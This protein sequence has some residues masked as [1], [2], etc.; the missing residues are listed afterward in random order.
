MVVAS[1]DPYQANDAYMPMQA[2]FAAADLDKDGTSLEIPIVY[3]SS[4]ALWLTMVRCSGGALKLNGESDPY[5]KIADSSNKS[6]RTTEGADITVGD[7]DGDGRSEI[8]VVRGEYNGTNKHDPDEKNRNNLSFYFYRLNGNTIEL[9][10]NFWD[11][12]SNLWRSND[13]TS[14][15]RAEAGDFDGNGRDELVYSHPG[16]SGKQGGVLY[17]SLKEWDKK[18]EGPGSKT[19]NL[20]TNSAYGWVLYENSGHHD[21]ALG[22]YKCTQNNV[23]QI[24]IAQMGGNGIDYAVMDYVN[25]A[26]STEAGFKTELGNPAVP[27]SVTA[28]DLDHETMILGEPTVVTIND[29]L[30]MLVELQAPP[31]HF[32]IIDGQTIDVLSQRAKKV[33]GNLGSVYSTAVYV[34]D[35]EGTVSSNTQAETL[36]WSVGAKIDGGGAFPTPPENGYGKVRK[37]LQSGGASANAGGSIASTEAQSNTKDIAYQTSMSMSI[38]TTDVD[39]IVYKPD[40]MTIYRYPVIY[41]VEGKGRNETR[42]VSG[43]EY[44]LS[45]DVTEKPS[46]LVL[47]ICVPDDSKDPKTGIG[48]EIDWYQPV[49]QNYNL[50]SYPRSIKELPKYPTRQTAAPGAIVTIGGDKYPDVDSETDIMHN[51]TNSDVA[52]VTNKFGAEGGIGAKMGNV[53]KYT[54]KGALNT[55]VSFGIDGGR[56]NTSVSQSNFSQCSKFVTH[57]APS[58]YQNVY[59]G[60]E[61]N[62]MRFDLNTGTLID[63]TGALLQ[64]N[65]IDKLADRYVGIWDPVDG[66]YS[67]KADPALNLPKRLDT[68]AWEYKK[69]PVS[70][71]WSTE[72]TRTLR[73]L[74]ICDNYSDVSEYIT[75]EDVN[76]RA[77]AVGEKYKIKVRVY[78]Y[79]FKGI[80]DVKAELYWTPGYTADELTPE[81]K[82]AETTPFELDGWDKASKLFKEIEFTWD[83]APDIADMQNNTDGVKTGYLHVKLVA[84]A[85]SQIHDDNDWGYVAC[86]LFD[87][88]KYFSKKSTSLSAKPGERGAGAPLKAELVKGSAKLVTEGDKHFVEA[89]VAISGNIALPDAKVLVIS[90]Q[91]DG[92]ERLLR[93]R[94]FG[95]L[96]PGEKRITKIRVPIDRQ[97]AENS[98]GVYVQV[99]SP[100]LALPVKSPVTPSSSGGCDAGL[101]FLALG[102]LLPF[103]LKKKR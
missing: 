79:S 52:S 11:E 101:G 62:D 84:P 61:L 16:W 59:L 53:N 23:K 29:H 37:W 40:V 8:V 45:V 64:C 27:V 43:E 39:C 48:G 51:E 72:E 92:S 31:K 60:Q 46:D 100:F 98:T 95:A 85:G 97:Y 18:L 102:A 96:L 90:K 35:T 55:M 69:D 99:I 71:D 41:P 78:N 93:G 77:V 87:P 94:S 21:L 88:A 17:V 44:G 10:F 13:L 63:E 67:K 7:F 70:S 4:D 15:I 91:K 81:R 42:V 75:Y 54:G 103:A 1:I 2:R 83:T 30:Q 73:G 56:S 34:K 68:S 12:A 25:G 76:R 66:P 33:D 89:E 32:D 20:N 57:C 5:H 82:V 65:L 74:S 80:K 26:F 22:N 9:M 49:H 6:E 19:L 36:S 38:L 24:G 3:S 50:F 28:V 47:Q 14:V 58:S 86:A